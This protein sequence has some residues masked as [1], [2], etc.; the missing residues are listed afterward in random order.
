MKVY[1]VINNIYMYTLSLI[2]IK[3]NTKRSIKTINIYNKSAY[4]NK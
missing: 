3:L 4:T 1:I 2:I